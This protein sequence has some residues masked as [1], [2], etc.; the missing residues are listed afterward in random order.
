MME[1]KTKGVRAVALVGPAGAGKTTLAEAL[2]FAAGATDRQGAVDAG[3]S[4]GAPNRGRGADRP[5]SICCASIISA[6]ISP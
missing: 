3:T 2:L 5:K 4:V 6:I 1:G